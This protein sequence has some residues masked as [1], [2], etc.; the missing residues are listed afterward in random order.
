MRKSLKTI[1]ELNEKTE[2]PKLEEALKEEFYRLEKANN[3]LGND[4]TNQVVNQF[5]SQLEEIIKAKDVKLGNV[6]LEEIE[7]F[8]IQLT[9][10]YQLMNFI[11]THN[12][13][14]GSYQWKDSG[15]ARTLLNKGLEIIGE[16]PN[17]DELHPVVISLIDLLPIDERPSGDNSVLVG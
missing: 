9:F 16:N 15:R 6:L 17:V 2:W 5:R 14:F 12:K 3:D 11:R 1:D 13:H 10:I 4:K 8:F 7:G